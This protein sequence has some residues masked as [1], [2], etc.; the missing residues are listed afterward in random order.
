MSFYRQFP[1]ETG[2]TLAAMTFVPQ[3]VTWLP[4]AGY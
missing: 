3:I 2:N 1:A 4:S